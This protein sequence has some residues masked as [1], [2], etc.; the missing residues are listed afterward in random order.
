MTTQNDNNVATPFRKILAVLTQENTLIMRN[1]SSHMGPIS[2]LKARSNLGYFGL[3]VS[4]TWTL[5]KP[6]LNIVMNA[7]VVHP[8]S[9]MSLVSVDPCATANPCLSW[10]WPRSDFVWAS[11]VNPNGSPGP[12]LARLIGSAPHS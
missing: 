5:M 12:T 8:I 3:Q 9:W 1:Q 6:T 2:G 7:L 4:W 10:G 11:N